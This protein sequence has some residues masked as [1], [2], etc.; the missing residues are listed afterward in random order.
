MDS[1]PTGEVVRSRLGGKNPPKIRRY[2]A[3]FLSTDGKIV[4]TLKAVHGCG[5]A[6]MPS[7]RSYVHVLQAM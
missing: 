1:S 4:A 5:Q 7:R 6:N 3:G 2:F